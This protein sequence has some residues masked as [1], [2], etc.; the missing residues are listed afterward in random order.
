MRDKSM[1]DEA[2][3]KDI[4]EKKRACTGKEDHKDNAVRNAVRSCK[5]KRVYAEQREPQKQRKQVYGYKMV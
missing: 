1:S 4:A 2:I 3:I 5:N